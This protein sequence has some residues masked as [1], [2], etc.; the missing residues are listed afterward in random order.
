MTFLGELNHGGRVGNHGDGKDS[1]ARAWRSENWLMAKVVTNY[2][3]R[4][5]M[6]IG[7]T[8]KY[9]RSLHVGSC[10]ESHFHHCQYSDCLKLASPFK[11]VTLS[12]EENVKYHMFKPWFEE[13][14]DYDTYRVHRFRIG[15]I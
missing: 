7:L 15:P 14:I 3:G 1:Y 2:K 4:G 6:K 13:S 11:G 8:A 5:E 10:M 9:T 12:E